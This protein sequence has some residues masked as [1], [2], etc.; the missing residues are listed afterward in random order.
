MVLFYRF[1]NTFEYR[2]NTAK[3]KAQEDDRAHTENKKIVV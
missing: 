1:L 3:H 2:T